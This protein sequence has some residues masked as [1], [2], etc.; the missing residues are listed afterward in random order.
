V[1][2]RLKR[3][4]V[5][6]LARKSP[7]CVVAME[8]CCGAHHLGWQLPAQGHGGPVDVAGICP[9]LRQSTEERHRDWSRFF[10]PRLVA[11]RSRRPA[12]LSPCARSLTTRVIPG[13]GLDR[14]IG[15]GLWNSRYARAGQG[16][17]DAVAW[18]HPTDQLGRARA[19]QDCGSAPGRDRVDGIG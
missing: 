7:S 4:A 5:V 11:P 17:Q 16:R 13:R 15:P 18:L 12:A 19:R 8:A 3:P 9:P 14:I 2:R 1:R 10:R 6:E